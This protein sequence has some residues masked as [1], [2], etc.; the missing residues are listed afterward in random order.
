M[1]EVSE[2]GFVNTAAEDLAPSRAL[3]VVDDDIIVICLT[4]GSML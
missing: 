4:E 2:A 3:E 1:G